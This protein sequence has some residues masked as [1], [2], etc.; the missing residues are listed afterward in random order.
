MKGIGERSISPLT[1]DIERICNELEETLNLLWKGQ[2]FSLPPFDRVPAGLR[3]LSDIAISGDGEPTTYPKFYEAVKEIIKVKNEIFMPLQDTKED[4]NG[5]KQEIRLP[6]FSL[7]R[8]LSLKPDTR[9]E[10]SRENVG[11]LP[12]VLITNASGLRRPGVQEAID[13]MYKN[14]GEVWA[15]LDAGSDAYY[16]RVSRAMIPLREILCN[17]MATAKRHP[18]VIQSC[19]NRIEDTPPPP[20]EIDAYASRLREIKERGGE[21]RLVQ[22]YTVARPPSEDCVTQ[23]SRGELDFIA[24]K[25]QDTT[26]LPAEVFC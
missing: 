3:R 4:E 12:L 10:F 15:K 24:Q 21:I 5:W 19:F 22:I 11:S 13:L 1:V 7:A 16:K 2:L 26:G 17:I 6:D 14:H 23:L 9:Q 18:I 8:G 25:V 20:E